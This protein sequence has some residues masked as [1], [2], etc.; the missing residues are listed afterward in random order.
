MTMTT[1][2]ELLGFKEEENNETKKKLEALLQKSWEIRNFEIE[3]FWKRATY[4]SVIVGAFL[5]AYFKVKNSD[6]ESKY[7]I[8]I[9]GCIS[10]FIWLLS[11]LGSK[12]WQKNWE[13]HID[14]LEKKTGS[15]DIYQVVLGGRCGAFSVSKLSTSLSIISFIAWLYLYLITI[16][17]IL[18]SENYTV[19]KHF[20][21]PIIIIMLL[22]KCR[23][24]FKE[25]TLKGKKIDNKKIKYLKRKI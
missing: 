14:L 22:L 6:L 20:I 3:L 18:K 8:S 16:F 15:G 10:S 13:K 25:I 2:K 9:L 23:T 19:L 5:V 21:L 4:F 17:P 7:L 11:N 1:Y 12:F 24:N